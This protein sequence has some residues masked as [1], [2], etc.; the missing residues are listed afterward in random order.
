MRRLFLAASLVLVAALVAVVADLGIRRSL[1][2]GVATALWP[3][4][5][6]T[7]E[8][9]LIIAAGAGQVANVQS[10]L[11][12]GV[13]PEPETLNAAVTRAAAPAVNRLEDARHGRVQRLGLGT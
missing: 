11:A 8:R 2:L 7:R 3:I 1:Y 4:E 6:D 5:P 10:L 13:R 9:A 12:E